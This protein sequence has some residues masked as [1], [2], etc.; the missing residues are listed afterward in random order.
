[1][2]WH[3]CHILGLRLLH[4]KIYMW[5]YEGRVVVMVVIVMMVVMVVVVI[6]ISSISLEF[7]V[8]YGSTPPEGNACMMDDIIRY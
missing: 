7:L 1:M 5:R 8:Q 4:L 2:R 6:V 3:R